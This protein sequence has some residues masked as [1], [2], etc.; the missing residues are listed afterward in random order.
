MGGHLNLIV[1]FRGEKINFSKNNLKLSEK[2]FFVSKFDQKY[3]KI[4]FFHFFAK[5][6]AYGS[7][8]LAISQRMR[9]APTPT[10]TKRNRPGHYRYRPYCVLVKL[11]TGYFLPAGAGPVPAHFGR[12]HRRPNL[13]RD[14][15]KRCLSWKK[16]LFQ[17]V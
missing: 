12:C 2:F 13:V 1:I 14:R 10:G 4:D 6:T 11:I 9:S 5:I 16:I 17:K 8:F 3:S 7:Q 15:K